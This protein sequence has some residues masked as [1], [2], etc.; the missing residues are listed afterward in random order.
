MTFR[1]KRIKGLYKASQR[2]CNKASQQV[3]NIAF[4]TGLLQSIATHLLGKRAAFYAAGRSLYIIGKT[5]PLAIT[6]R[7]S[8][9]QIG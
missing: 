2:V 4:A 9:L 6:D 8:S 3:C 1:K 7:Y 5:G